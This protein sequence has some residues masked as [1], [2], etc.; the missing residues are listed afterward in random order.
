MVSRYLED[1]FGFTAPF[2]LL[3]TLTRMGSSEMD[4]QALDHFI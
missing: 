1:F 4:T 2:S 3:I